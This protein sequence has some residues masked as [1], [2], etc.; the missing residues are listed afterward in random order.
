MQNKNTQNTSA[1]RLT[2]TVSLNPKGFGFVT[3][4][5]D[6]PFF[7]PPSLA[8]T[9]L[10]GDVV[11]F[12]V[13]AGNKQG[14]FQAARLKL[15]ERKT[16]LWLG[17]V[18]NVDGTWRLEP[19]EHFFVKLNL[20]QVSFIAPG[21]V[22]AV[23]LPATE[24]LTESLDVTLERTLGERTR[25]G[26]DL[27]Y[28]LAK[29]DFPVAFSAGAI[30]QANRLPSDV[31]PYELVRSDRKDLRDVAFVTIDGEST[32]DFDDAV[33][34]KRLP[35]GFE[36][37]VAI[38]DV[39]HYVRPG[40]ALDRDAEAR[41][42]SVYLPGRTVPMLPEA[43]SNGL[44]SLNPGADRLAVV[45]RIELSEEGRVQ[46]YSFFRALIRSKARLTYNQVTDILEKDA[47]VPLT[48]AVAEN[49]KVL[50]AVYQRLEVLRRERG[51]L[52]FE[53]AEPK[54]VVGDDG[55]VS[56]TW[57]YRTM[58]HKLVEELMLLANRCVAEH[59]SKEYGGSL[60]RHQ[61]LPE[62]NEWQELVTWCEARGLTLQQEP[63]ILALSQLLAGVRG[64]DLGG[65]VE[66]RARQ[67]MQPALYDAMESSHF[68][69]GF[70]TYA[71]FTSPIRR[72][73]DLAVHR[74]LLGEKLES[75]PATRLAERCSGRSRGARLAERYVWDRLKKRILAR[76]VPKT[77]EL[78]AKMVTMG[79]R[80]IRVVLDLWQ[81]AA[82]VP[83]EELLEEGYNFDVDS[84]TWQLNKQ[85]VELG[86]RIKVRWTSLEE[87]RNR[88]ELQAELA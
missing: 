49:L 35:N 25:K 27:D 56:L 72:Y 88:T 23:R 67:V 13:E 22:V 28:V 59:L 61:P 66:L 64:T 54:L 75:K 74:L 50:H 82:L 85:P 6:E 52:E 78:D 76:D 71:H 21:N 12:E 37:Q 20:K 65:I 3:T 10:P 43:L 84:Q 70:E 19:D 30:Q 60:F 40:S 73:A 38:A 11:S 51:V 1:N 55:E 77:S 4:T 5:L 39:S 47:V 14:Q 31:E 42:T 57:E 33:L 44:C 58:A 7:L 41:S 80:G 29:H 9:V 34:A 45:A 87:D 53:D 2:G 62:G 17:T 26:F 15:V 16:T 86:T 81:C 36:V 79:R 69:L 8:R 83:A 46:R 63:S 32:R 18:V 48:P 24:V 68:S